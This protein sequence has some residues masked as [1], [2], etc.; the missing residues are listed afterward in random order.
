LVGVQLLP[1]VAHLLAPLDLA[2]LAAE[3]KGL[4]SLEA[5][6]DRLDR[7]LADAL[8]DRVIDPRVEQALARL[9]AAGGA[10]SVGE[11]SR[12][13]GASPRNLQRLMTKWVGL[14]PKQLARILRFQGVLDRVERGER[15]D[16]AALA[17]DLGYAD[18]A[19]LVR[20]VAAFAGLSPTELTG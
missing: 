5:R 16:W 11:L 12:A 20:E 1:G 15:F 2:A 10:V 19:H 9:A 4:P 13:A 18:Q 14:G 17:A 7:V 8:G 3:L 6:L